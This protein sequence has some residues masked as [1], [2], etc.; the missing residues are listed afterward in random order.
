VPALVD[1]IRREHEAAANAL[2]SGLDHAI[3]AGELLIEAK[4]RYCKHGQ[5]AQ[6]LA[7]NIDFAERTAQAYMR[8]ARL[9]IEKRNAVADLPLREALSAIQCRE[10]KLAG[11]ARTRARREAMRAGYALPGDVM[12]MTVTHQ[13]GRRE[14]RNWTAG[15]HIPSTPVEIANSIISDLAEVFYSVCDTTEPPITIEQLRAAFDRA[16]P[17]HRSN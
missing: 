8:L 9:P 12:T 7:D 2:R 11:E 6:W 16:F 10:K 3:K 15:E 17:P 5:W 14:V 1:E 13:D 4:R